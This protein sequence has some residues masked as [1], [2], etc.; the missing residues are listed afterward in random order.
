MKQ[1]D[2]SCISDRSILAGHIEIHSRELLTFGIQLNASHF[3]QQSK[4][5]HE[6]TMGSAVVLVEIISLFVPDGL[7]VS[8]GQE[9]IP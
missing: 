5:F 8:Y 1:A 2:G 6:N 7:G 3:D 9:T 4:G